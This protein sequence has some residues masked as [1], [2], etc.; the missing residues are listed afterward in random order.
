MTPDNGDLPQ[1][2]IVSDVSDVSVV[3]GPRGVDPEE[4]AALLNEMRA[5]LARY[6]VL[7]ESELDTIALWALHTFV[8]REFFVT[9]YLSIESPAIESGKTNLLTVLEAICYEAQLVVHMSTAGLYQ[10]IEQLRRNGTVEHVNREAQQPERWAPPR[11]VIGLDGRNHPSHP[12]TES[13]RSARTKAVLKLRSQGKSVRAIAA[14]LGLSVGT[15][16]RT[17]QKES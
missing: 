2:E 4:V 11:V 8:H 17:I 10:S 6:I 5:V 13:E 9:P 1:L 7:G 16:H 3:L 12:L 14:E 15:V